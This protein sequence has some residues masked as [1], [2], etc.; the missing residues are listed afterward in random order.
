MCVCVEI[1]GTQFW[2]KKPLLIRKAFDPEFAIIGPNELLGLACDDA[3][4]SR[5]VEHVDGEWQVRQ[6][7]FDEEDFEDGSDDMAERRWTVLVQEVDRHV[8][9]VSDLLNSFTF[10]P[11]WR[12][13]D[14]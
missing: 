4:A 9:E 5:L 6:G 3:V 8:P 11:N 14:M 2:Q 1:W 13:D 10:I 12:I 7:P